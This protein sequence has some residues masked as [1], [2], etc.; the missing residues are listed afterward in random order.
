VSEATG[1]LE[2]LRLKSGSLWVVGRRGLLITT[3]P[4]LTANKTSLSVSD[5]ISLDST[6]YGREC[7]RDYRNG[8]RPQ[9]TCKKVSEEA[10]TS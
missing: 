7:Q 3:N 10:E 2:P 5:Q 1:N 9:D 8:A 6:Q 4:N